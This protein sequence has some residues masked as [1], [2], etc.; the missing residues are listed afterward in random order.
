MSSSCPT[1]PRP[2]DVRCARRRRA[3][4]RPVISTAFPHAVELLASGAGLVVPERDPAALAE[5]IRAVVSDEDLAADGGRGAPA[6]ARPVVERHRRR[7][8]RLADA[9]LGAAAALT[10]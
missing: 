1:T 10:A 4:G 5:A 2:G 6:R 7:Y 3:A 9:L 8:G